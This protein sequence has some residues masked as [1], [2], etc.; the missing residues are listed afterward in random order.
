MKPLDIAKAAGVA[1]AIMV[2]NV[3]ISVLVMVV[4]SYLIDPGHERAFYDA[5]ARRIAPWS[6]VVFGAPLFFFAV[7][8]LTRRRP[9]RKAMA[10]AATCFGFYAAVDIAV[11]LGEASWVAST[12]AIAALSL[13]TKLIG[14][15]AGARAQP[16]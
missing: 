3:L 12:V 5:A 10:F 7:R 13:V 1:L 2:V 4:Y 14:A 8:W 11:L 16:V 6:S 15:L 9:D